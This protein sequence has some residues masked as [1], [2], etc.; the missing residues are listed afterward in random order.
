[1][2]AGFKIL[3]RDENPS[4]IAQHPWSSSE[5]KIRNKALSPFALFSMLCAAVIFTFSTAIPSNA[6]DTAQEFKPIGASPG[7]AAP[8]APPSESEKKPVD[9]TKSTDKATPKAT[10][11]GASA[12]GKGSSTS[13]TTG[14]GASAGGSG[15]SAAKTIAGISLKKALIIG[16]SIV[17]VAALLIAGGSGG[18]DSGG[19]T[20]PTH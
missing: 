18:G 10:G 2:Q 7:K 3:Y 9:S 15:S 19:G 5:M 4:E 17:G 16:G 20:N 8:A 1:L 14:V 6:Q 12:K 11:A 13:K